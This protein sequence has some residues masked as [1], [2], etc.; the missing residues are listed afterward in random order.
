[1]NK[2]VLS[3]ALLL[4]AH[5]HANDV[6]T[7]DPNGG[8]D[9]TDLISAVAAA[10]DSDIILIA[11]GGYPAPEVI[12]KELTLLGRN[13]GLVYI[14][15]S[16]SVLN[17]SPDKTVLLSG[18]V[19]RSSSSYSSST[20]ALGVSYCKG[21]VRIDA[22]VIQG[23]H[24]KF[25]SGGPALGVARSRD[26]AIMRS[27][28][29]GG[30]CGVDIGDEP[31]RG[32]RA[33]SLRGSELAAWRSFFTGGDGSNA[34]LPDLPGDGGTALR[35]TNSTLYSFYNSAEG[36]RGGNGL[37]Q[38]PFCGVGGHGIRSVSSTVWDQDSI[39]QGGEGGSGTGGVNCNDG[40]GFAG[41]G[42]NEFAGYPRG[43]VGPHLVM[44]GAPMQ[45]TV[46]GKPG[47]LAS[48]AIS[49]RTRF[50]LEPNAEG[51]R[52]VGHLEVPLIPLGRVDGSGHLDVTI[53]APQLLP[54]EEGRVLYLQVVTQDALGGHNELGSPISLVVLDA[55]V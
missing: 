43:L 30:R 6:L 14:I 4:A 52:L 3:L 31:T 35:A 36:G 54:G 18:L 21:P 46:H 12:D 19:I 50:R 17:L 9:F 28:L 15:G 24:G 7:V 55:G 45:L 42:Q 25:G 5:A 10:K 16:S 26:V 40:L 33:L 41:L 13:K 49:T 44:D 37:S 47:E 11:N 39:L 51:G 23:R 53:R 2:I 20:P 38:T 22:C 27:T 8:G 34:I 1:M 32:G 29:S 48:L